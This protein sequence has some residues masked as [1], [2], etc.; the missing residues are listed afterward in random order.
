MLGDSNASS[1]SHEVFTVRLPRSSRASMNTHTSGTSSIPASTTDTIRL[2]CASLKRSDSGNM[3][4]VTI[5][6]FPSASSIKDSAL[7]A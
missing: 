7:A 5:T 6:G 3:E 1:P 2:R 4:P